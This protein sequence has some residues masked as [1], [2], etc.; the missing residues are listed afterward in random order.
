MGRFLGDLIGTLRSTFKIGRSNLDAGGLSAARNLVLPDYDAGFQTSITDDTPLR[1]M[2]N[3]AHGIGSTLANPQG[4][5]GDLNSL[6]VPS[7]NW[8]AVSGVDS[9]TFPAGYT[10]GTVQVLPAHGSGTKVVRQVF[11]A[12]SLSLPDVAVFERYGVTALGFS[13]WRQVLTDQDFDPADYAALAGAVFTGTVSAS[14]LR[15]IGNGSGVSNQAVVNFYD[16]DGT[17]LRAQ[18]GDFSNTTEDLHLRATTGDLRLVAA[19]NVYI[20]AVAVDNTDSGW[21][22]CTLIGGWT[23]V[24]GRTAQYRRIGKKV[25]LRGAVRNSSYGN[26][27]TAFWNVPTGYRLLRAGWLASTS[28]GVFLAS[29]PGAVIASSVTQMIAFDG[30]TASGT[31]YVNLDNISWECA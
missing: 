18:I 30:A 14:Q 4:N 5:I 29:T 19:G 23:N 17:T 28:C 26:N 21:I 20:D 25:Y 1:F 3:G 22:N 9:G 15:V 13:A 2:L 16:S 27:N 8:L 12:A 6:D 7:G 24:S 10:R 31:V 11:R